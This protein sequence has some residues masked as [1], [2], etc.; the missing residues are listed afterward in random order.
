MVLKNDHIPR[1]KMYGEDDV[2]S[3][4]WKNDPPTLNPG[5]GVA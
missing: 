4:Y 2:R 5:T 1:H 3:A